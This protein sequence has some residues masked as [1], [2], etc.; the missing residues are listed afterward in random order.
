V[1][2]HL[3]DAEPVA[4]GVRGRVQGGQHVGAQ[5]VVHHVGVPLPAHAVAGPGHHGGRPV[6][7]RGR[8]ERA[9]RDQGHGGDAGRGHQDETGGDG[10]ARSR[11]HTYR[12][13]TGG[14]R[15]RVAP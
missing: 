13:G 5:A 9:E 15:L 6:L 1:L 12:I 3:G 7:V 2:G 8:A 14:R 10:Q 11:L 4:L